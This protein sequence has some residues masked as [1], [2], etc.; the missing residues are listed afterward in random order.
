MALPQTKQPFTGE[1]D[2][3]KELRQWELPNNSSVTLADGSKAVFLHMDGMY[4]KWDVDGELKTGNFEAF[5][6]IEGG[7]KVVEKE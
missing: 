6:K 4:A 3:M 1:R 7:Y 2:R 5:E